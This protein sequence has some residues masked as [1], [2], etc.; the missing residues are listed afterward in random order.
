[1]PRLGQVNAN[2]VRPP[3]LQP[4]LQQGVAFEEF[5]RADVGHRPLADAGKRRAP[6][7]LVAPVADELRDERLRL[8]AAQDDRLVDAADLVLAEHLHEPAF[9]LGA[10]GQ[11]HQ[12]AGVAVEAMDGT[13]AQS[14]A[15]SARPAPAARRLPRGLPAQDA[16]DDLVEGGLNLSPPR[17]PRLLL[18]VTDG[19]HAGGLLHDHQVRVEVADHYVFGPRRG[20]PRLLPHLDHVAGLEPAALV[21]R[22]VAV[23]LDVAV[24]DQ[25]ADCRPRLAGQRLPQ[26]GVQ[27]Q[28]VLRRRQVIIAE[29]RLLLVL[30]L[31]FSHSQ[32]LVEGGCR[33]QR[34]LL[35]ALCA[36][37]RRHFGPKKRPLCNQTPS[38]RVY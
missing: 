37:T 32:I 25:A 30:F 8:D 5:Q 20:G 21:G 10:E 22:E 14:L 31:H 17:R 12:A 3:G 2:L 9:A 7:A 28:A 19:G 33:G 18:A 34:H 24:L 26:H 23:D 29:P 16:A 1:M 15:G 27:G 11:D 38:R 6:A 4:A 36:A 13:D 35:D